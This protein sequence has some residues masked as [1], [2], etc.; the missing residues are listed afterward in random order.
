[1]FLWAPA[2]VDIHCPVK[3]ANATQMRHSA[4]IKKFVKSQIFQAC[5]WL[6][7]EIVSRMLIVRRIIIAIK[8]SPNVNLNLSKEIAAL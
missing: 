2:V 1:M 7:W 6:F 8:I 3:K 4:F 5:V